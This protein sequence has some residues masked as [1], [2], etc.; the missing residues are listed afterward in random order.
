M[1]E[2]LVKA[3]NTITDLQCRSMRDNLIFTGIEEPAYNPDTPEDTEQSLRAFLQTEMQIHKPIQ[4]HR[5]HRLGR[6]ERL[7]D[8]LRPIIAKFERAKDREYVRS[9]APKTLTGKPFGV[10]EQFP[11][12]VEDRRNICTPK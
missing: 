9:K 10:R 11:K 12:V 7:E 4:F 6:I 3:G 8:N 5:V 2:Q 1:K